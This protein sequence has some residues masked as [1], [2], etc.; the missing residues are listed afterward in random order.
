MDPER[1][2]R[3]KQIFGAVVGLPPGEQSAFLEEACRGDPDLRAKI[4]AMIAAGLLAEVQRLREMGYPGTLKSMQSIGYRHMMDFI[5]GRLGWKASVQ[6]MKRDTRRYAK[7]QLT[8]F[9]SDPEI[10]WFEPGQKDD[11]T[12]AIEGFLKT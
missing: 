7:R 4:E 1:F 8:W 3:I 12:E 5:E 6:T 9:R 2:K 10:V 11:M